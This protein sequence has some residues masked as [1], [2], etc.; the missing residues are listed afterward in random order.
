MRQ[1]KILCAYQKGEILM[2]R[3][4]LLFFFFFI[5]Y[6]DFRNRTRKGKCFRNK[7][8]ML[9][10]RIYNRNID[11]IGLIIVWRR[12][13]SATIEVLDFRIR[14]DVL[15]NFSHLPHKR[16]CKLLHVTTDN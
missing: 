3:K 16:P 14:I 5:F 7:R 2:K 4:L 11:V 1:L 12:R 15:A 9:N 8:N 10:A 6:C 13:T